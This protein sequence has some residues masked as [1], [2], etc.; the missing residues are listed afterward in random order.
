M[1]GGLVVGEAANGASYKLLTN[2]SDRTGERD[3]QVWRPL[4]MVAAMVNQ[5]LT[6]GLIIA[7]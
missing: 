7:E 1:W 3:S 4:A 6:S 5:K 2:S